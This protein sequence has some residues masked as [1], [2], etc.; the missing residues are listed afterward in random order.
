MELVSDVTEF[1]QLEKVWDR[2]D[3]DFTRVC[4]EN[5]DNVTTSII[6]HFF[7]NRA[8]GVAVKDAG[9]IHSPENRS[10]H[11]PV[12]CIFDS[13]NLKLDVSESVKPVPR[14]SW[15]AASLEEKEIYKNFLEEKLQHIAV[16]HP[17]LHCKDVKCTDSAHCDMVDQL[18]IEVLEAVQLAADECL[19]CPTGGQ[20]K[21]T[22]VPG[23]SETVQPF[24]E[25]AHFWHQVWVSNGKPLHGEEHKMMKKTRNIY[26]YQVRKCKKAEDSIRKN[27]L[28]NSCLNGDCG[29]LFKE[30]K[31]IRR[32]KQVVATSIDG[33]NENVPDHFKDIYGKLYNSVDDVENMTRVSSEV[34]EKITSLTIKDVMKVTPEVVKTAADKLKPGKSDPVYTFS[35]DCIKVDSKQLVILLTIIIKCFLIHGHVTRFLLLATLVPII[36]DKLGS[37]TTSKNY[38]SIAISSLILKMLDWIIILLFGDTFGLHDLQ[39]AYQP[40][41]SGNMCTFAVLE[42]IDYFLRNGSEVFMCTMDMSKAFDVTMHSLLFSKMLKAGLSAI[43]I[44]LLIFIYSEQ[45]ANV[46]WNGQISS[47]FSMH[48]GVRQGAIL[49]AIAYCFYCEQLFELLERRRSGCWVKGIFLGL[50]GYSD[51]NIC[52]APSLHAL[53]NMLRTCEEFALS[54]NLKFSTD[55]DPLKCK[56][57]TLAFLKKARPLPNLILCGNPL[58]WTNKCKHL[59]INL[60]NKID[61]CQYD[62]KVK[63]AQYIG[64]NL[65]LNQEFHFT[66]PSTKL[67]LN[68]IYNSHYSGCVLWNLFSPGALKME[69][70]YNR[71]VKVMLDLPFATHRYLVEPLT[72]TKHIKLVLIKRFLGFMDKIEKSGKTAIKIL[73]QEAMSDVRSVTGSNY[74]NI[75]LL[76]GKTN[77]FDVKMEDSERL[78][79]I[80]IEEMDRWKVPYIKEIIDIK[81]GLMEVPGFDTEELDTILCHLC[82]D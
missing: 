65:E 45:F 51:D 14:P 44:R 38:R 24:K 68:Q 11:S 35:S 50:L 77:V 49:S 36:K 37:I 28:L 73:K 53:Q 22:I 74:R 25:D 10:D 4:Y 47:L 41:I 80:M 60:E 34:E 9:V 33:V 55:P 5:G 27:K 66:H 63:N 26:H 46:R 71:S 52:L 18:T 6:D 12:Y 1:L 39:F 43:F 58:P 8:L 70:T 48:N 42:T 56:T 59:G 69:S 67:K 72:E 81:A 2:F 32:T 61:G 79:Y 78:S 17:V 16:P 54:H 15:K 29:D 13:F 30:I 3:I 40:G 7:Y 57:K 31:A 20:K 23:W 21:K 82:T 76:L 64:K 62:M 75:M 19:P